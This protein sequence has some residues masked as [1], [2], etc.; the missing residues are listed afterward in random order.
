M[1]SL[2]RNRRGYFEDNDLTAILL[3]ATAA[4]AGAPGANSI[5]TWARDQ[6]V[7]KIRQARKQRVCSLNAFRYHLGLKRMF[8][9]FTV[10]LRSTAVRSIDIFYGMELERH[11]REC[12]AGFV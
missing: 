7:Q 12:S 6:L 1:N 3:N 4:A 9:C 10:F 2:K 8:E 5:A 11:C